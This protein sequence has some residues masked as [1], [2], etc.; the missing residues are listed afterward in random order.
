MLDC[1]E[2]PGVEEWLGRLFA[3]VRLRGTLPDLLTERVPDRA[4]SAHT[5]TAGGERDADELSEDLVVNPRHRVDCSGATAALPRCASLHGLAREPGARPDAGQ[6]PTPAVSRIYLYKLTTDSGGAPCIQDGLMTLAICKPMIR[7]TA[8]VED[9]VF[10]FAANRMDPDGCATDNHLIYIARVD[11]KLFGRDYYGRAEFADRT[12]CVYE[13]AGEGFAWRAGARCHG[14]GDLVHDL[15]D[16]PTYRRAVVL[17]SSDFRY[18]G[19]AGSSDYKSQFPAVK[20]AVERMGRGH[21]VHHDEVLRRELL[22]LKDMIWESAG[23]CVVVFPMR[24]P[25]RTRRWAAVGVAS[26][27][28]RSAARV[29]LRNSLDWVR[30]S[31]LRIGRVSSIGDEP[32][33]HNTTAE[34]ATVVDD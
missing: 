20:D 30:R 4:A 14:P 23:A 10:G 8:Q 7:T 13:P 15:G 3:P 6:Q 34:L 27:E 5:E 28:A 18:F 31:G 25:R 24:N 33:R 32:A 16:G 29:R 26:A 12:D 2:Y 1:D 22:E 17:A 9:L 21:R 19:S 11:Q